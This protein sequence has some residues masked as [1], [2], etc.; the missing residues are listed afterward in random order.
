VE[1]VDRPA[2]VQAL[3]MP[4]RDRGPGVQGKS[5]SL[6]VDADSRDRIRSH[7]ESW[8][9]LG[10]HATVRAAEAK[11]AVFFSLDLVALF[12]NGPMVSAAQQRQV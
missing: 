9:D 11:V 2:D 7:V 3:A 10:D 5:A 1:H 4:A 8:R 6:V 12:V